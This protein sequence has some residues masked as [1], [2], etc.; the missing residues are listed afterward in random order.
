MALDPGRFE[1]P[2]RVDVLEKLN[3][4]VAASHVHVAPGIVGS[5]RDIAES[6]KPNG[7]FEGDAGELLLFS[8]ERTDCPDGRYTATLSGGG[9]GVTEYPYRLVTGLDGHP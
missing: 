2:P 6:A 1:I 4:V 9:H 5:G 7:V 8:C 3:V